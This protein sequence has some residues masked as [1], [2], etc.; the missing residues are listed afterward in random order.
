[1]F[2]EIMHLLY[3]GNPLNFILNTFFLIYFIVLIIIYGR[4]KNNNEKL[5]I[6]VIMCFVPLIISIIHSIIFVSGSAFLKILPEYKGIYISSIL[7]ALS[8]L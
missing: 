1:M 7:I 6:W 8:P 2:K 5:K 4:F 3:S